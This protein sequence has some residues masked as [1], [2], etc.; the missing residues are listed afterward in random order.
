MSI[1]QVLEELPH[2]TSSER[3]ELL[4]NVLELDEPGVSPSELILIEQRLA[5]HQANPSAAIPMRDMA[6]RLRTS[7]V[8]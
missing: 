8:S 2:F 5:T 7:F 3:Q 4:R 1:A 6:E